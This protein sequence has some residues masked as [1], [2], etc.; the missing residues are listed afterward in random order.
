MIERFV[1]SNTGTPQFTQKW[2]QVKD[3]LSQEMLICGEIQNLKDDFQKV[4][5]QPISSNSGPARRLTNLE[6]MDVQ[7]ATPTENHLFKQN[8]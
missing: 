3:A 2:A 5:S 1:A 6:K 7:E 4:G 8:G